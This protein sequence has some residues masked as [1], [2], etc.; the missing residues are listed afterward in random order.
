MDQV[1][2]II[3]SNPHDDLAFSRSERSSKLLHLVHGRAGFRSHVPVAYFSSLFGCIPGTW[4]SPGQ[5]SNPS[6]RCNLRHSCSNAGPLTYFIEMGIEPAPPQRQTGS[7][8]HCTTV[9]TPQSLLTIVQYFPGL[10]K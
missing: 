6:H 5:G 4:K 7:L 1:A 9:G 3:L 10:V 2:C 8:T